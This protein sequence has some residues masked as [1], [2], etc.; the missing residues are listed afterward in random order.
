VPVKGPDVLDRDGLGKHGA[1]AIE[2][3]L[4]CERNGDER[5]RPAK[6]GTDDQMS[7]RLCAAVGQEARH[8]LEF[9]ARSSA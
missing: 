7:K 2:L 6:T 8:V 3:E 1:I 4:I 9:H 5:D